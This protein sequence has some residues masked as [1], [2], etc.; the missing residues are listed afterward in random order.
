MPSEYILAV[1][2]F[3]IGLGLI[4][5]GMTGC[6]V[7]LSRHKKEERERIKEIKRKEWTQS[8]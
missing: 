2:L 1:A 3:T 4:A 8:R 5:C 6:W 7:R